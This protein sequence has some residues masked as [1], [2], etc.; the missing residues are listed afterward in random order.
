[1]I[2][3]TN[4]PIRSKIIRFPLPLWEGLGVRFLRINQKSD[5]GEAAWT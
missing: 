2:E 5:S 1:M 4:E 3:R